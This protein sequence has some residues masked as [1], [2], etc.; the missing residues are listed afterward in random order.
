M[1]IDTIMIAE[2]YYGL[3]GST[4]NA[5]ITED[6]WDKSDCTGILW[7]IRIGRYYED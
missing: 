1:N 4:G 2:D 7:T 5:L 3:L 6:Y